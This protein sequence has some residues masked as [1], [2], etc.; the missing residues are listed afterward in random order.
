MSIG[1]PREPSITEES[2]NVGGDLRRVEAIAWI[3]RHHL[4]PVTGHQLGGRAFNIQRP[5][6]QRV[7]QYS[8]T[9]G[10]WTRKHMRPHFPHRTPPL[11][12]TRHSHGDPPSPQPGERSSHSQLNPRNA[13]RLCCHSCSALTR[14]SDSPLVAALAPLG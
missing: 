4:S 7:Y 10:A 12:P 14:S 2:P 13:P 11:R 5:I 1:D 3:T 9:S 8:W 6:H